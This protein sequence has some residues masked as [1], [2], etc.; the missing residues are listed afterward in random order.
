MKVGE[1]AQTEV[2]ASRL[3][4]AAGYHQPPAYFLPTWTLA[5]GATPGEK[6][7]ARFRPKLDWLDK[8]GEWA[9]HHNPFVGTQPYR[10]L[11]VLN[12][13]I[14]NAD[15]RTPN[16]VIYELA[17]ERE[18]VRRWY[19]VR[20]LGGSF[21]ATG[22]VYGTRNDLE[23]F[24]RQGLLKRKGEDLEFD[25]HGRHRELPDSVTAADAVWAAERWA[26]LTPEQWNDA[27]RAA[28]YPPDVAARYIRKL[29][30]KM[31]EAQDAASLR[32]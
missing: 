23:G 13:L 26:R 3:F 9:W 17:E 21:G 14:N 19:V 4:W 1:E 28:G 32:R 27:F 15:L 5:G 7:A 6:G 25:Y 24:E 10:G 16:N 8:T 22:F 29:Q 20:D 18:G 30:Q 31:S 12:L 2:V 11:I